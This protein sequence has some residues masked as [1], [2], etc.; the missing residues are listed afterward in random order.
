MRYDDA[1][2]VEERIRRFHTTLKHTEVISNSERNCNAFF[3]NVCERID[4][5]MKKV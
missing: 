3:R 1:V 4:Q 5:Q 2:L